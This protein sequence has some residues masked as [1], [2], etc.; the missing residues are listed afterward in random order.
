VKLKKKDPPLVRRFHC[1]SCADGS[2][3]VRASYRGRQRPGVLT[4]LSFAMQIEK[5]LNKA[6]RK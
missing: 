3:R 4:R 1:E 5:Q 2:Y 6:L